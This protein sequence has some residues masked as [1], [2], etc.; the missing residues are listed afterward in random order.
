MK[1]YW[2]LRY[3]RAL[4]GDLVN[5]NQY[6]LSATIQLLLILSYHR[7]IS[8]QVSVLCVFLCMCAHVLF[9][10]YIEMFKV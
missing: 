2:V 1:A 6:F 3:I 10:I 5:C 9:I 4:Y 7:R 8:P